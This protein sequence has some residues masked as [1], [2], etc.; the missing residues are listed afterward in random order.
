MP[1]P[2]CAEYRNPKNTCFGCLRVMNDDLVQAERGFG[3]HP[4]RDVEIVTYVVEGVLTHTVRADGLATGGARAARTEP[5]S[6]TAWHVFYTMT[7]HTIRVC[8]S[9]PIGLNG[10]T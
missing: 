9:P 1:H 3:T 6:T 2:S 5:A 10:H 4:H 8:P 7:H